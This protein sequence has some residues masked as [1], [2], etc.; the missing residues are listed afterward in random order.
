[1]K[2]ESSRRKFHWFTSILLLAAIGLTVMAYRRTERHIASPVYVI[3]LRGT[4]SSGTAEYL[5]RALHDAEANKAQAVLLELST[6]GGE[7]NAMK[8]IGEVIDAVSLPV[9]SFVDGKAI[10]A[11][12]YIALSGKKVLMT[13]S[14]VMGASQP[15]TV[16]GT[17]LP[18]KEMSAF[19]KIFRARAEARSR[20]TGVALDPLVAE[21]MVDP[22]LAIPGIIDKGK[23]LTLTAERAVELGYADGIANNRNEALAQ[24]DLATARLVVIRPTP[25]EG[26]VR[27]LTDPY[28]APFLLTIGFTALLIE[29][30]TAGFGLAGIVGISSILL[31]FGARI[32]SGLAGVEVL[33]LFLLGIVLLVMELFVT[34]GFGVTGVLG[35]ASIGGSVFLSYSNSNEAWLS[36]G[37]STVW[38]LVLMAITLQVL[39]KSGLI[40]RMALQTSQSRAEGY[41]AVPGFDEFIGREGIAI[42]TLRPAGTGEFDGERLDIVS[43][44]DFI[45]PQTKVKIIRVEGRRI[46]VRA[47]E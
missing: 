4:I 23:L 26:L 11:G 43:E 24:L 27:F 30:F 13:P 33:F 46:V 29:V 21:A 16:D 47:L 31:F 20:A 3:S 40:Q 7:I 44:G 38:T 5:R 42:S 36:L 19:R 2:H 25:V 32:L 22:E 45:L 39:N 34:P 28:V 41:T 9:H 15:R 6:F 14:S 35:L 12:A 18:E 17:P 10:S 8:E 1:M 37:L